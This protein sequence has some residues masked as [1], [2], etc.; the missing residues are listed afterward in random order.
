MKKIY[1]AFTLIFL[2]VSLNS[3]QSS[4]QLV[5]L[6]QGFDNYIGSAATVPAG[7]YV[8]WNS[9]SSPSYYFTSGNYG[10]AIPSYKFGNNGDE[11]ISPY[12]LSGDTLRFWYKGQGTFS[13]QNTLL[14]LSSEDS[15]NWNGL[16]SM[17]TLLVTG[18]TFSY[19]LPC[20]AHYLMF[21]YNQVSGN[22]A[23][24]DVRVTMTN[25]SPDAVPATPLNLHCAG[26]TVCF[27]DM[28]TIAGCDSISSRVWDFGDSSAVDNSASPC[29]FFSQAGNYTVK[30]FV[31]ASNGNSD[32]T[33][34]SIG[35]NPV[36]AAQF[37]YNNVSGI[38]VDFTDLSSVS[39][40]S[41]TSWYW[42]FGD[43]T[44]SLQHY[45]SHSFA[46]V[47]AYWVCLT[48]TSGF[49]CSNTVC[50]SVDVIGA[51]IADHNA[52][53]FEISL[54]PNPAQNE[55]VAEIPDAN[56]SPQFEMF[57]MTGGEFL[58][59]AERIKEKIFRLSLPHIADGVYFLKVK[60]GEKSAVLKVVIAN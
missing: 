57:D 15:T 35:V 44:L 60:T 38:V 26:D 20:E 47:G 28:S 16:V 12:F 22:L 5:R 9:T 46:A 59:S 30:L 24:D 39:S 36:P 41:I 53:S 42:D 18:T 2:T 13:A 10:A 31:T 50:D 14:I 52:S 17:D 37:S 29:H 8:S 25:Y 34:L 3:I 54:F 23:F 21:I 6:S 48:A 49:G 43:S 56:S 55:I 58:I 27:F 40:G 19:P 33:T 11:I 7:W 45:P 51:G 1:V 32:S 4:A